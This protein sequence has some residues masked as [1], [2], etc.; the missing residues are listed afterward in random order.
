VIF[1]WLL[2]S[3]AFRIGYVGDVNQWWSFSGT[4]LEQRGIQFFQF[5]IMI[6]LVL[7]FFNL[8]PVPPLDGSHVVFHFFI[9][10]KSHLYGFWEAY[11]RFGF[12]LFI[13]LIFFSPLRNVIGALVFGSFNLMIGLFGFPS[14]QGASS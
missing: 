12:I 9:R 13:F 1:G 4:M 14:I 8:F 6:N 5:F 11:S 3:L 10:G 7:C 2:F